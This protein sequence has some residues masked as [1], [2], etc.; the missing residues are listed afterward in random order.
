MWRLSTGD[1]E[2]SG[3]RAPMMMWMRMSKCDARVEL[4]WIILCTYARTYAQSAHEIARFAS[5]RLKTYIRARLISF[6]FV[7][8]CHLARGWYNATRTLCAVKL[9]RWNVL[10][11]H[12]GYD[13]NL[14][15]AS[16]QVEGICQYS[17]YFVQ[18]GIALVLPNPSTNPL[19][20]TCVLKFGMF[21]VSSKVRRLSS[22]CGL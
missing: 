15:P 7:S 11:W 5:A 2:L 17:K 19:P 13:G 10:A 22:R 21:A 16:A 3:Q 14:R 4:D 18:K 9:M 8:M 6:Q 1:T 12:D 20:V